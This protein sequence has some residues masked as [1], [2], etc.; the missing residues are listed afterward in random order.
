MFLVTNSVEIRMW[1]TPS[2]C[3]EPCQT[4]DV[5]GLLSG[6]SNEG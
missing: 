4:Y 5:I 3:V 6:T 1:I 2:G